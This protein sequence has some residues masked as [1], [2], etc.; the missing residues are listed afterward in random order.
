MYFI[1]EIFRVTKLEM[2]VILQV[3]TGTQEREHR[4]RKLLTSQPS[5]CLERLPLLE[6]QPSSKK[7][8]RERGGNVIRL[9]PNEPYRVL[10]Q[11]PSKLFTNKV[12]LKNFVLSL[13]CIR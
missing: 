1:L 11:T 6:R 13:F 4:T 8:P 2:F 7:K 3:Q 5:S 12:E 10:V 9:I